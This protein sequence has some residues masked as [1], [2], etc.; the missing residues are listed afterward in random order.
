MTYLVTGCA[1]FIGFHLSKKLLESGGSV[2]GVDNLNDYY[3]PQL[4]R[5]R[6]K[7]LSSY[8]NFAFHKLDISDFEDLRKIFS[9]YKFNKIC[10]LAA[11]AGVRYSFKNP[12]VY[13]KSNVLGFLNVLELMKDFNVKD[14]VY[15][16]SS[17]VYGD[18]KEFPFSEEMK[19]NKPVSLYAATKASNEL[20][21]YTYHKLYKINTVGLRFFTVYGPWGR[22]D[23]AYF[24]FTED[25]LKDRSIKVFNYGKMKRDFTYI[26]D[27]VNGIVSAL[28]K[29]K[30]LRHKVINLGN[31]NPVSLRY[32]IKCLEKKL[33]KKAIKEFLPLQKGD[34]LET[35]ADLKLAK[36]NLGYKPTIKI[37]AGLSN[38]VDWYA[39]YY[40]K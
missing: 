20:F 12:F 21:A 24:S 29:T 26:D 25:I 18:I 8:E 34:V 19:I 31:S 15:A 16:S 39:D 37:D 40:K 13:E 11:Q 10:N 3:D 2:V 36:K 28:E 9:K 14:L 35:Y 33:N 6:L 7:I 23:M 4:K 30:K 17:S 38:F 32:F 1:G 27:I 22:P 5:D